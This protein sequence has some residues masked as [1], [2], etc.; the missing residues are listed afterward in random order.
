VINL[1]EQPTATWEENM[2][3]FMVDSLVFLAG[4]PHIK[5][6]IEHLMAR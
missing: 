3:K 6:F 2:K 5:N 1:E 4:L